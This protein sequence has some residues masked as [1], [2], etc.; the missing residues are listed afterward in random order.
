[1]ERLA[2]IVGGA[3]CVWD[4]LARA[5]AFAPF[6]MVIAINDAIAD[7]GN[8]IDCAITLHPEKLHGWLE[9]R[10][11]A[12]RNRP[13]L[14]IAHD[15]PK[16]NPGVLTEVMEYRWPEMNQSGSSGLFAVKAAIEKGCD[17][18]LLCGVPMTN[19]PHY[20]D[21]KPWEAVSSFWDAWEVTRHRH[22]EGTR[23]M[24]GRTAEMFGLPD[25]AWRTSR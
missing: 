10:H 11:K 5:K 13:E 9:R 16:G 4:D 23:S 1:M 8:D 19:D 7:Y 6:D 22:A 21:A 24:S 25:Q 14:I 20:H 2:L 17:G 18:R 12:G 15:H 3:A